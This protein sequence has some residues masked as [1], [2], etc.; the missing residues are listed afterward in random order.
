MALQA[1]KIGIDTDVNT[2]MP[3]H[4]S[5]ILQI[6][7]KIGVETE[8]V[9]YIF[10]TIRGHD[11]YNLETLQT[12]QNAI[13]AILE[14]PEF[15]RA[16]TPF[17][18]VFFEAQG[19]RISP[20]TI[21]P[22]GRAPETEEE[23]AL[24]EARVKENALSENFVTADRG[25]ILT[26]VFTN[27]PTNDNARFMN[28]FREAVAPLEE[29]AT[30]YYTGE[31]PFQEQIAHLITKDFSVLLVLATIAILTIFWL[32]FRSLRAVFLPLVVVVIGAVW[33]LGFMAILGFHITV[34]TIIIPSLILSIGSSYTIHVLN[35]YHRSGKARGVDKNR[36]LADAVE[37]VIQTVIVAALTTIISFLSL[38][39]TTLEPLQEFG[40]SISL[41]IFF[42]A[43]LALFFLPAVFSLFG[44]PREHHRERV[45]RGLLTKV[46]AILGQWA[47]R[48][49][50]VVLGI[51]VLMLV[52]FLLFYP[53]I[54]QQADYFSYFPSEDR[55]I[56]DSRFINKNSGGSQTFNITLS[57]PEGQKDFFL[58]PEVLKTVDRFETVLAEHPSITNKL[59]FNGILKTINRTV[60]GF[61]TIPDSRGLI[62]LLS[63]YFRMIPEDQV[64]LG[65]EASI[66]D[67]EATSITIYLKLAEAETYSIMNE[68]DVRR[69]LDF[70]KAETD[71]AFG[72]SLDVYLWGNTMLLLDSSWTIKRDQLRSALISIVLGM[73]ITWVFFRSFAYSLMALIP[74]ISGI[75]FYFIM[76]FLSGI[77]LDMTT[78]LVTN[79]T[80]GIGL[81]DA[82][83]FILQYRKQ[84]LLQPYRLALSSSLCITG[85]PIV[86]TTLSLAAGLLVLCFASFKPI[87]FFGLLIAGTLFS[88][89]IATVVFIPAAITFYETFR[90]RL[91]NFRSADSMKNR[92]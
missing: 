80:I 48:H 5:R 49:R 50:F 45:S 36:W 75:F 86:L 18:F 7:E 57:A 65:Q 27:E 22:T 77:P 84:R 25:R 40:L 79:V 4:N 37:H 43:V 64:S 3:R 26:A 85:R 38:L 51:F 58:D 35:E 39:F 82:V 70:V 54:L 16:I 29:V 28:A 55:I 74:L 2:L 11:L 23:L 15:T 8:T 17:N 30:V 31:V 12:F 42:C 9:F 33:S 83:H 52:C 47:G 81:D 56:E 61:E 63:R 10:V 20:T 88:T 92:R 14:I 62:L 53:H 66:I 19:R 6:K 71:V 59:S 90:G 46:V 60:T 32:S 91:G 76:L 1:A 34:I 69:F 44:S 13:D 78:I 41:G 24:F 72:D 89:M 87:I 68:N 67:E 21:S 73:V